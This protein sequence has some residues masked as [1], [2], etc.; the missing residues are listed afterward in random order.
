MRVIFLEDVPNQANAGEV[1]VV[2]DGYARNYL[3][4]NKLAAMATAEEMKRIERI[5]RAGDERRRR[6]TEQM[7]ELAQ[8]LEGTSV[9]V[10][11]RVTPRGQYYGA[12]TAT[13]IAQELAIVIER[14]VDHRLVETLG[15]HP[16]AR[17][18]RG[19]AAPGHRD[20]GHHH[21]YRG[22]GRVGHVRRKA[23]AP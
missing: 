10:K 8:L 22:S 20:S 6:E 12:I 1:K 4:P 21:R 13:Q 2:K 19:G 3:I 16:R 23:A 18:V 7:E 11:A 5:R 9:N 15:I 14:E 17:R